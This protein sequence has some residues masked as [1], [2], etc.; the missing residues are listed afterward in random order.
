[1]RWDFEESA[2]VSIL[3]VLEVS[4]SEVARTLG[5][6]KT[7]EATRFEKTPQE[8]FEIR[9][10]FLTRHVSSCVTYQIR[11]VRFRLRTTTLRRNTCSEKKTGY[12][13]RRPVGKIIN[14][15]R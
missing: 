8:L 3:C 11:G 13:W 7:L 5:Q 4:I 15:K 2:Y 12:I 9:Y 1:M 10:E 14:L 6:K